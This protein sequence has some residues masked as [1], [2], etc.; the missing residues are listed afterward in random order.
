MI[1]PGRPFSRPLPQTGAGSL[2]VIDGMFFAF[3]LMRLR[4]AV[5]DLFHRF[6]FVS[7]PACFQPAGVGFDGGK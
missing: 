4:Q 2:A 6:D 3:V 5:L 1:I 7:T